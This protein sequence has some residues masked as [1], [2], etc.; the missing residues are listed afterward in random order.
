MMKRIVSI[1]LVVLMIAA[2]F[3][4]C[5]S[6]SPEG[7]YKIKSVNGKDLKT[8]FKESFGALAEEGQE[9]TDDQIEGFLKLMGINSMDEFVTFTLESDGTFKAAMMGEEETGTWKLEGDKITMTANGSD[10]TGT[11][12]D[13][14]ITISV[15]GETMVLAK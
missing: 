10:M 15:D 5:S 8:Y 11:F 13:G 14:E 4:G 12:K 1:A 9:I 2:L 3:A 6:S 7:T